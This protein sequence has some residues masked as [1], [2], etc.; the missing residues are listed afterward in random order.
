[1]MKTL[2]VDDDRTLAEVIA[3]TFKREGFD[4]IMAEE[5]MAALRRWA[6]DDPDL[7]ILD[8][9]LPK[10][11]G[12]DVCHQI[13][14]QDDTP[15]ILLTVRDS[16]DDVVRGLEMGADDYITKP[17]SPKQLI[18]R[19]HAV[20]RRAKKRF[21]VKVRRVG[22]IHL[23]L[24]RHEITIHGNKPIPLTTLEHRLIECLIMN[25]GETVT[26][27]FISDYVWGPLKGNRDM[28]RQLVHRLRNKIEPD[29]TNPAIIE[30]ISGVG[31]TLKLTKANN[32]APA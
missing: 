32:Q 18:A 12:F 8:V 27:D 23:D 30:T 5:G 17:F 9:N 3:F 21:P 4:V 16:D 6:E 25:A 19:T 1:M 31:Y 24:N 22:G 28:L 13:R 29:P 7:I 26:A 20:L 11:N 14:E 2:I 15:I 10:A